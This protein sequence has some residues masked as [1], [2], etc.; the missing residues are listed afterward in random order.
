MLYGFRLGILYDQNHYTLRKK[1][2]RNQT[3]HIVGKAHF[4]PKLLFINECKK[5][6]QLS[7]L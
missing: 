1:K 2:K 5:N 7:N 4:S 6:V 3:I